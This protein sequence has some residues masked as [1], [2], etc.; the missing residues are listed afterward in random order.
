MCLLGISIVSENHLLIL[1]IE[2]K[3]EVHLIVFGRWDIPECLH[4]L[5][6]VLGCN[7]NTQCQH[8][9]ERVS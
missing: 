6:V 8:M 3:V 1:K 2:S 7:K 4:G 5:H 9:I